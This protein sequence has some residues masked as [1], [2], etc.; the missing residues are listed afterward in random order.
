V[1][2]KEDKEQHVYETPATQQ[3]P[4]RS[5]SYLASATQQASSSF[6]TCTCLAT[7]PPSPPAPAFPSSAALPPGMLQSSWHSA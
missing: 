3:A 7:P 6:G 1:E 2:S 4:Q 5:Y